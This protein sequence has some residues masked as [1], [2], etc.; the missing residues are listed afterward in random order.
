MKVI[1]LKDFPKLGKAGDIV[2]VKDG[3]AINYL[4][5]QEIAIPATPKNLK[6]IEKIKEF[7]R[8]KAEKEKIRALKLKEKLEEIGELEFKRKAGEGGKLFGAVSSIDVLNELKN[9]NIELKKGMIIMEAI[10]ELGEYSI[11]I[12]LHPEIECNL[13]IKIVPE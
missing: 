11:R 6:M 9:K 5:P 8:S 7:N 4:I 10:K 3:Y 12:K 13:K 2:N 1:L